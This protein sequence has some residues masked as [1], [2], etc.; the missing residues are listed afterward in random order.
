MRG[1]STKEKNSFLAIRYIK[2]SKTSGLTENNK[3]I[4]TVTIVDY[5]LEFS[6]ELIIFQYDKKYILKKPY[7]H[8]AI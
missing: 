8:L 4:Q 5:K 3:R 6:R 2:Q 1:R 7:G